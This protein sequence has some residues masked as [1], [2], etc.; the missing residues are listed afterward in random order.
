M[1]ITWKNT[2]RL[3]IFL[4]G[5][6]TKKWTHSLSPKSLKYMKYLSSKMPINLENSLSNSLSHI[7]KK[8]S[9]VCLLKFK[10]FTKEPISRISLKRFSW[11][12]KR[13]WKSQTSISMGQKH[14]SQV[15]I[16]GL[17]TCLPNITPG[18]SRHW[19]K[20]MTILTGQSPIQ[21]QWQSFMWLRP[22]LNT[23]YTGMSMLSKRS[24]RPERQILLIG[25]WTTSAWSF[26]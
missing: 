21:W 16:F 14:L 22:K 3:V 25:I 18:I 23:S 5:S 2:W 7:S 9:L 17:F 20:H 12:Q 15:S 19:K 26:C 13:A 8:I 6:F 11:Q 24:T 4:P 10:F 1:L